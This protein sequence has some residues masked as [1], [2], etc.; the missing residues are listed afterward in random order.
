MVL[1]VLQP[2]NSVA[3]IARKHGVNA[4]LLFGWLRLHRK[5]LSANRRNHW[6]RDH[7]SNGIGAG[8]RHAMAA[9]ARKK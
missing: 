6:S 8:G 4:N 3:S 9:S 5:L 1:E 7:N 2:G